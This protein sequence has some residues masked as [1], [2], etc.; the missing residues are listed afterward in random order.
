MSNLSD[1]LPAGASAKQLT[2]TDSG[3]GISSKA[4]CVLESAGTV[5]P[6]AIGSD[7]AGTPTYFS[8]SSQAKTQGGMASNGSGEFLYAYKNNSGYGT[9]Q[10][11]N[12][13]TPGGSITYGT[14]VV[15][16]SSSTGAGSGTCLKTTLQS[17]FVPK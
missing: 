13:A 3:S 7:S 11:I 17:L 8:G 6:I 1:L 16:L 9:V 4:P 14:P 5:S 12:Y 10:V 2:F 15:Y